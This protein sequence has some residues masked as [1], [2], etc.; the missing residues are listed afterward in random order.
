MR[1]GCEGEALEPF[2][3]AQKKESLEITQWSKRCKRKT[4]D[5]ARQKK[6]KKL[7]D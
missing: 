4:L 7:K 2:D 6:T 5:S 1:S 3:K